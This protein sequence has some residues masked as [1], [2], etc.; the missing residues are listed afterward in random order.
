MRALGTILRVTLSLSSL[1][2][3]GVTLPGCA[4]SVLRNATEAGVETVLDVPLPTPTAQPR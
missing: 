1:A 3:V 4:N 2:L